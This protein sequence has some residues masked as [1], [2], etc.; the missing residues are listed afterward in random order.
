MFLSSSVL[1]WGKCPK[2]HNWHFYVCLTEDDEDRRNLVT[3]NLTS[4]TH[5]SP[6]AL[7]RI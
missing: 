4:H 5:T 7:T 3:I 2:E 6:E 1:Q